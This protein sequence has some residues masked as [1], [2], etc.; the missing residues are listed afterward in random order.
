MEIVKYKSNNRFYIIT[1]IL[2]IC[3]TF[4]IMAVALSPNMTT[5][6]KAQSI[7]DDMGNGLPDFTTQSDPD[8]HTIYD[9]DISYNI[10][11]NYDEFGMDIF[12][13]ST[14]SIYS[15]NDYYFIGQKFS[16]PTF[17]FYGELGNIITVQEMPEITYYMLIASEYEPMT[18]YPTFI[19]SYKM[20]LT[21]LS[22]DNTFNTSSGTSTYIEY[23]FNIISNPDG[24]TY[25]YVDYD[26]SQAIE[27]IT[28]HEYP[29]T[30]YLSAPTAQAYNASGNLASATLNSTYFLREDLSLSINVTQGTDYYTVLSK[31]ASYD[32]NVVYYAESSRYTI[33]QTVIDIREANTLL[34]V[35]FGNGVELNASNATFYSDIDKYKN[36]FIGDFYNELY[37]KIKNADNAFIPFNSDTY[38]MDTFYTVGQGG[39]LTS[40]GTARPIDVGA[41]AVRISVH[42]DYSGNL[43]FMGA[44]ELLSDEALVYFEIIKGDYYKVEFTFNGATLDDDVWVYDYTGEQV[45]PSIKFVSSANIFYDLPIGSYKITYFNESG[46]ELTSYPIYNGIYYVVVENTA[47]NHNLIKAFR[48]E[49]Y[50]IRGESDLILGIRAYPFNAHYGAYPNIYYTGRAANISYRFFT[51]S[52]L[53]YDGT[54]TYGVDYRVV[55]YYNVQGNENYLVSAPVT[56]GSYYAYIEFLT[57]DRAGIVKKTEVFNIIINPSFEAM[58]LKFLNVEYNKVN[59]YNGTLDLNIL[60][61]NYADASVLISNYTINYYNSSGLR[62][63]NA[64]TTAGN[65]YFAIVL[66]N[67]THFSFFSGLSAAPFYNFSESATS[68]QYLFKVEKRTLTVDGLYAN[69]KTYDG[70]TLATI[71]A[72]ISNGRY[73]LLGIHGDDDVYITAFVPFFSNWNV[74]YNQGVVIPQTVTVQFFLGGADKDKYYLADANLSAYIYPIEI[75]IQG[76][77]ASS[78]YHNSAAVAAGLQYNAY[79]NASFTQP[80]VSI[81]GDNVSIVNSPKKEYGFDVGVYNISYTDLELTGSDRTNY[82]LVLPTAT[83]TFTISRTVITITPLA[84]GKIYGEADVVREITGVGTFLDIGYTYPTE[85]ELNGFRINDVYLT[86]ASGQNQGSYA[87]SIAGVVLAQG[88]DIVAPINAANPLVYKNYTIVLAQGASYTISKKTIDVVALSSS[89][90]YGNALNFLYQPITGLAYDQSINVQFGISSTHRGDYPIAIN[91]LVITG[92]G[93]AVATNNYNINFISATYSITARQVIYGLSSEAVLSKIYGQ[94]DSAIAYQLISNDS[95]DYGLLSGHTGIFKITRAPGKDAGYYNLPPYQGATFTGKIVDGSGKDVS[96]NYAVRFDNDDNVRYQ[97]LK[98]SITVSVQNM[99]FI[100]YSDSGE[101]DYN[102]FKK[103]AVFTFSNDFAYNQNHTSF[104][105]SNY[106]TVVFPSYSAIAEGGEFTITLNGG[107]HLNYNYDYA[108]A[109]L[110]VVLAQNLLSLSQPIVKD[111]I[112]TYNTFLSKGKIFRSEAMYSVNTFNGETPETPLEVNLAIPE[113]LQ[114]RNLVLYFINDNGATVLVSDAVIDGDNFILSTTNLGT[115]VIAENTGY[116]LYIVLGSIFVVLLIATLVIYL[117]LKKQLKLKKSPPPTNATDSSVISQDVEEESATEEIE[118]PQELAFDNSD[119]VNAD[120]GLATVDV[121][122]EAPLEDT[123]IEDIAINDAETKIESEIK[124]VVEP[125]DDK[126]DQDI[127]IDDNLDFSNEIKVKEDGLIDFSNLEDDSKK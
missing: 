101:A 10:P 124:E 28:Y 71:G 33:K 72:V 17:S 116:M 62:I 56:T 15:I 111:D 78:F 26:Y 86:R 80:F 97:I 6:A 110:T 29:F 120:E 31:N 2:A 40:M 59:Y 119:F 3:L 44:D 12:Y 4:T 81:S 25:Y 8:E 60:L 121:E 122:N 74:A 112:A 47:G 79:A 123:A 5:Y 87:L 66:S 65:Y 61:K 34:G 92:A 14:D 118:K 41:Y 67:T 76:V 11:Y 57:G 43:K 55:S 32:S 30:G 75:Y 95:P 51:A 50:E 48:S 85:L 13:N 69:N 98:K 100:L 89:T 70:T 42:P 90:V 68:Q 82:T 63:D 27:G 18:G 84:S 39:V 114:G 93:G 88:K 117:V 108:N 109:T 1:I 45:F 58:S 99:E 113:E 102:N 96:N 64:P 38:T 53:M 21:F 127:E 106:P 37:F 83:H 125:K 36:P 24:K 94:E 7:Y 91:S 16:A 23:L 20:V 103:T 126:K 22:G 46:V 54:L 107:N 73:K 104:I 35:A 77:N 105:K 19:G 49:N 52:G 115:Y 9:A